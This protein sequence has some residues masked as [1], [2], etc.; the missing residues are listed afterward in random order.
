[1]GKVIKEFEQKYGRTDTVWV[2]PFPYWVDTRL[3][4]VWAGIPNRDMAMWQDN[5]AST[6]ELTGPKLFMVKANLDDPTGND[7]ASL[8]ILQTLYPNGQLRLFDS[9]VPGHDFWIF[10]V[11]AN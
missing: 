6:V 3:P 5:L 4:A 8:N 11:P 10:T 2:V 1:M 9:D 7:Q